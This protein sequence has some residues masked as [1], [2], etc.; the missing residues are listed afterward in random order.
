[1]VAA[2]G[3]HGVAIMMVSA[4]FSFWSVRLFPGRSTLGFT[5]T[6]LSMAAGS[7][8][9]PALAGL[10]AAAYG[11]PAMFLAAAIP[12]LAAAC[13]FGAKL[14]HARPRL[15]PAKGFRQPKHR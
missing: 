2:S 12:P 3:L 13:W 9:G 10:L 1:V 4:V 6:L 7:V 11:A 14:R 5:A 8:A 15:P